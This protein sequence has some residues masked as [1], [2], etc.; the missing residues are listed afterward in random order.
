[1]SLW[2]IAKTGSVLM[3][4]QGV[5]IITQLVLPP[6][7]LHSYGVS[8]YGE[9][10]TLSA[11]VSYLATLNFG[12]NTFANNQVTIHYNRDEL[13]Q[14]HVLQS[15]ALLLM[16]IIIASAALITTFVF[17][18]PIN[19]WLGLR[20]DAFTVSAT[21][22]FLGLQ[23]LSRILYGFIA[24]IFLAI[25]VAYR[26]G[27]WNNILAI[28]TTAGTTAMALKH[29][30]FIWI[31]ALQAIT[32]A[33]FCL[34]VLIDLRLTAP[35]I[36]P[37]IRYA[38]PSRFGEVLK[39]SGFFGLL[40]LSNFLAYQLPVILLQR[41][42][43]PATVVAFSL[44]RTIFSMSRQALSSLSQAIGPE[45]T[46]LYGKRSW[47]RLFRLYE[48]SERVIFALVPPLTIG[49]LLATPLLM[50][51]WLHKRGLY[52]PHICLLM[53]LVSGLIGIKDH[54]YHFQTCSNEH[55]HLAMLMFWSY[56]A[57]TV[58]A[59]PAIL[60]SGVLGFL[61]VWFAAE[62]FQVLAIL[63]LNQR[64]FA[65]VARLDFSPVYKLFALMSGA[66]IVGGWL[67]STAGQ[68]SLP[69]ITLTAVLF[70][71]ILLVISYPLFGLREVRMYLRN[72]VAV[73]GGRSV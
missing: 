13:D 59:V 46:E 65:G 60:L 4:S 1:M 64:L 41:L 19:V 3:S 10:L 38:R 28:A 24:G 15:T 9:W 14:A 22:Y 42:L 30:S 11:T 63:R 31:A 61:G 40:F 43:G 67:A 16:L 37:R 57:M 73:A 5:S 33:V 12:L 35:L 48:L 72:R 70:I 29:A 32:V 23:V 21:I 62:L 17:F 53:A 66:T 27:Y 7:F 50:T 45:I 54:K 39:P 2:R 8:I 69:I 52:D 20:T 34:F 55:T 49:T 18:L 58:L 71:A 68:K 44:T 25:G 56:V 51:V 26:A 47:S 36:F 6:I